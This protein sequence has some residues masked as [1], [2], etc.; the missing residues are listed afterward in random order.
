MDAQTN[1]ERRLARKAAK[2]EAAAAE[3][4]EA[5]K[6]KD[7]ETEEEPALTNKEQRLA[8]KAAKKAE[9][10]Q[11]TEEQ[12]AEAEGDSAPLSHKEQRKRRKLEKQGGS[13][14]PPAAP[15]ART[16]SEF[17]VWVGNMSF[18]TTSEDLRA[19]L[20]EHGVEGISRIH[21]P[22]GARRD[23]HNKGYAYVDLPSADAVSRAVA[24]SETHVGGRPLLIKDG[25]DFRGRPGLDAAAASADGKTG[26]TKTAQKILH[27]Q[28]HPAGPTLFMGNLSFETTEDEIRL[29]FEGNAERRH[30][31]AHDGDEPAPGAGIRR[32]R[33][34]TF[35]DSGKCK[36][37]AFVDFDS[38]HHATAAL[39]EPRNQRLLGRE[40]VLQFAGIDAIRRGASRDLLPDY[41]PGRRRRRGGGEKAGEAGGEDTQPPP[42][43]PARARPGAANAAAPRQTYAIV[44]SSGTRVTFE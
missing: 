30:M 14:P 34:G 42:T 38:A 16:R 8:R 26:L 18:R 40:L 19:W 5:P 24:L 31:Q 4:P 21:M 35:E 7:P 25:S 29:L 44:P 36:G 2:A 20:E 9:A 1:K 27:A 43:A 12:P 33:M 11:P 3:R 15:R 39:I 28:R 23:E 10:E 22:Q 41:V 32:I 13:V 37:F 17:S 6:R